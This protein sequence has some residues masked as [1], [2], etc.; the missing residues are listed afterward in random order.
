M[1]AKFDVDA[2]QSSVTGVGCS[3]CRQYHE[4]GSDEQPMVRVRVK[5]YPDAHVCGKCV[6]RLF[7]QACRHDLWRH[8]GPTLLAH[9]KRAIVQYQRGPRRLG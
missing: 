8:V 5:C 6:A 1:R 9:I 3:L 2:S 7:I 4:P